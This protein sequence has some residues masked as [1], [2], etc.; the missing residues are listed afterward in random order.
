MKSVLNLEALNYL[1]PFADEIRTQIGYSVR[2][3]SIACWN[4]QSDIKNSLALIDYALKINVNPSA[5]EKF[6]QDKAE[7]KELEKKYKGILVC[8]FCGTNLPEEGCEINTTIYKETSRSWFLNRSVQYTYTD[9]KIPRCSSCLKVHS[10]G[11]DSFR[12]ALFVS[13]ILGFVIGAVNGGHFIIGGII[14]A[15]VGWIIGS[16]FE[17]NEV[18]NSGIKDSSESTLA[19]H[20]LLIERI[21]SGWTFTKPTA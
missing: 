9:I 1:P 18:K 17:G 6:K 19:D 13:L 21:K 4:N 7:L 12:K 5:K 20:P 14:G 2:S 8:H 11:S 3:M 10:K 16:I 15:V